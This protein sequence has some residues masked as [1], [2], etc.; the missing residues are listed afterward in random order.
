MKSI[1]LYIFILIAPALLLSMRIIL[2][3]AAALVSV[4]NYAKELFWIK[5]LIG[6]VTGR[7]ISPLKLVTGEMSGLS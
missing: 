4:S 6:K 2:V 3:E 1:N 7:W 5:S